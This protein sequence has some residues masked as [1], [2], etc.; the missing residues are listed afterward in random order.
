MLKKKGVSFA[1]LRIAS[2]TP[3]RAKR[4][5]RTVNYTTQET[6]IMG[7]HRIPFALG[8]VPDVGSALAYI[9][10]AQANG[11]ALISRDKV[12]SDPDR[13]A[14]L[15]K[16]V[17]DH[18][19]GVSLPSQ[20]LPNDEQLMHF[21]RIIGSTGEFNPEL[22]MGM[23]D[24]E[25]RQSWIDNVGAAVESSPKA[26]LRAQK[27]YDAGCRM[28]RV[29]SP[30]GGTEIIDTVKSLRGEF[31]KDIKIIAGQVMDVET[32]QEAQKATADA[33]IIGVAGGS[34]CTTSVNADIPVNTPNTHCVEK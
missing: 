24:E 10:M 13:Q 3:N 7:R 31:G 21:W 25:L 11:L 28:F 33:I 34:Q 22:A 23:Y 4:Q 1:D 19:K 30:E 20:I 17:I 5:S 29:Y 26:L 6:H 27:L 16:T 18:L 8:S 2:R 14:F 15:T 32:A 12:L 9:T